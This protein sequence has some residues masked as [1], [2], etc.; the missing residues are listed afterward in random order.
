MTGG[1][2]ERKEHIFSIPNAAV[3]Y[4][5]ESI[6]ADEHTYNKH[7]DRPH[8]DRLRSAWNGIK[9]GAKEAILN[10]IPDLPAGPIGNFINPLKQGYIDRYNAQRHTNFKDAC[11]VDLPGVDSLYSVYAMSWGL[12]NPDITA[13][14]T[15]IA[16]DGKEALYGYEYKGKIEAADKI[17]KKIL[18]KEAV[19][20]GA[21]TEL[22]NGEIE[23][24]GIKDVSTFLNAYL[25]S[26]R[27]LYGAKGRKTVIG[28][29]A[30]GNPLFRY[31]RPSKGEFFN[32]HLGHDWRYTVL[33]WGANAVKL[34]GIEAQRFYESEVEQVIKYRQ[35]SYGSRNVGGA[36]NPFANGYRNAA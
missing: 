28:K 35:D 29:D 31:E 32:L 20:A 15:G 16:E 30:N 9:A 25:G 12:T 19:T 14:I 23:K 26:E 10:T 34:V 1:G 13:V 18:N 24:S 8:G 5:G 4:S 11:K 33:D 22:M 21:L 36:P 3:L 27:F 7:S 2:K 6:Y 17:G